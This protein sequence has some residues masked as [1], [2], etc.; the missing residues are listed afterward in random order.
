MVEGSGLERWHVEESETEELFRYSG[1]KN[2]PA[3]H[4]ETLNLADSPRERLT[5]L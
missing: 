2:T 1:F 5:P 3:I 4:D